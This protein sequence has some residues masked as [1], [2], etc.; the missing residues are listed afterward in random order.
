MPSSD[1]PNIIYILA[2]DM[3]Y[4]DVSCLNEE[5][6]IHTR[7][8]DRVAAGGMVFRDAHASSAVCTPSRYSIVTGRYKWRSRLKQGVTFGYSPPLIEPGRMTVASFLK[9]HGYRTCCVGKWHLGWDW[10]KSGDAEEDVDFTRAIENGPVTVGF[11]TFF[12]I[13]ASLD[14]APYVY[15]EDDRPTAVPDRVV[16][17]SDG[18][19]MWREGPMAP[20]FR[21]EDVLPKLTGKAL[22]FI[23]ESVAGGAPFFLYFPLPAPHTPILPTAEFQG[24]SGTNEYGDFCLQVDDVVG[25]VADALDRHGICGAACAWMHR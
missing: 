19:L 18:K 13:S 16:P 1:R 24:K 22:E 10:A 20:D 14:M 21:H 11:D 23:D 5:S 2:D 4:G 6:R 25:Q 15:V 12:G 9:G 3:G 8:L 7:H 17:K